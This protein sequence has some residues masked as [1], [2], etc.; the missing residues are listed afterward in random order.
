VVTPLGL[1]GLVRELAC[2]SIAAQSGEQL[3][4]TIRSD[5]AHLQAQKGE[6]LLQRLHEAG[7][8]AQFT[9][10]QPPA[11]LQTLAEADAV[12]RA[13][14]Q[15]AAREAFLQ[16]PNVQRIQQLFDARV[17]ESSIEPID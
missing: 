2:Q 11:D 10:R 1:Q 7:M 5:Q 15:A 3:L 14:R 12:A 13:Q 17:I 9:D 8:K 6:E 16:D 4:L